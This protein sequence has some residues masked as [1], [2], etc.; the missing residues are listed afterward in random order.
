MLD[1]H[2]HMWHLSS[3][4]A[5]HIYLYSRYTPSHCM[6]LSYLPLDS[7][8]LRVLRTR[9]ASDLRE[10]RREW[11]RTGWGRDAQSTEH[12]FTPETVLEFM[13]R[14]ALER[15]RVPSATRV[16]TS[17]HLEQASCNVAVLVTIPQRQVSEPVE[18]RYLTVQPRHTPQPLGMSWRDTQYM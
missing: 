10:L 4:H 2:M 13:G 8:T 15:V 12:G 11:M 7:R 18:A 5:A 3:D 17:P 1:N 9:C 16:H 6:V 14:R